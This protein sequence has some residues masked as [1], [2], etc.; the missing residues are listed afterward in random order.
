MSGLVEDG[1]EHSGALECGDSR[2]QFKLIG[3]I[4][5]REDLI[6]RYYLHSLYM[7]LLCQPTAY[8]IRT[9]GQ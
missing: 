2:L 6:S 3:M 1:W 7:L 8:S 9:A 4:I 5:A